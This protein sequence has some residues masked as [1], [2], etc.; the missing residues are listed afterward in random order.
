MKW[1]NPKGFTLIELLVVIAIIA[2]LAALLLPALSSAKERARRISCINNAHNL[3]L[4]TM[5]Y[6]GDNQDIIPDASP[7]GQPHWISESFRK[8]FCGDYKILRDQFFCPSNPTWNLDQL[9]GASGVT[10]NFSGS[11]V[12]GYMYFGGTNYTLSTSGL[13]FLG[14]PAGTSPVFALKLTDKP[15]FDVLWCDLNRKLGG[16]WGKPDPSYPPETRAV[17]HVA[18]SSGFAPVG[19]NHGFIDGHA[20]WIKAGVW[21]QY[22]RMSYGS[23]LKYFFADDK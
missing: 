4:A 8:S 14:V 2:I 7:N 23:S 18:S 17:N 12:M 21:T 19:A 13:S 16:V 15:F 3:L 5:M 1:R 22:P 6:A 20:E 10:Y 11:S 9:W